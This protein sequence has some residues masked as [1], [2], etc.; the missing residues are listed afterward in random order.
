MSTEFDELGFSERILQGI[1]SYGFEKPSAIQIAA[2]PRIIEGRD[3]IAQAQSGTGKTATFC[4]GSLQR[5]DPSLKKTQAVII[6]PTRELADQTWAVINSLGQYMD[7][8]VHKS[9]GG[10]AV[11]D[12]I[13]RLHD[14]SP[15][16]VVG[17]PGRILQM[18]ERNH[19]QLSDL[20]IFVIDE[21]DEMLKIGFRDQLVRLFQFIPKETQVAI[22]SATMP[23]EAVEISRKFLRNP[24]NILVQDE[25]L[26]LDGIR[27]YYINVY[28]EDY[29]LDT[30]YDL[31]EK[32][33]VAQAI[34]FCNSKRKVNILTEQLRGKNFTV[35]CMHSDMDVRERS[36]VYQEFKNGKSRIL[37]TTDILA[38]G[39]DIQS[40]SFV[41]NYDLPRNRECYIH[42]IG[43][44]GRYGKKGIAINFVTDED[45]KDIKALERFYNTQITEMPENFDSHLL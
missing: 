28:Q 17:T 31:Y 27:Q 12:E 7:I 8:H 14:S 4:L 1:F 45:I 23:P 11:R 36:S 41:I 10:T 5:I 22:F 21:A 26:T 30:L 40:I 18:V 42:R 16:A 29:K 24:V 15:E 6:S 2:I 25:Q 33:S 3:L 13:E 43:R 9:V 35:S 38:R 32:L 39:I 34:I 20:R 19:L 44:S 37:V